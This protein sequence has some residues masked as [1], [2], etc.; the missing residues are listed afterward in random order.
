MVT[1]THRFATNVERGAPSL[2]AFQTLA[3]PGA[4]EALSLAGYD[5]VV[6]DLQHGGASMR[7]L[8]EYVRAVEL[9][10]AA[11]FVRV[12]WP[13]PPDI[14]RAA[15]AGASGIVVPMIESAEQAAMVARSAR[16]PPRGNRS[17]GPLRPGFGGT[18]HA[19]GSLHVVPMIETPGALAA[20]DD[21]VSI[22]GVDG[23]FVGPMD[24]GL[25]LGATA[26]EAI[27]HPDTV[28]GL[29]RVVAAA[30]RHDVVV[31]TIG[32]DPDH[33]DELLGKGVAWVAV[34]SD[35]AFVQSGAAAAVR[36]WTARD[37]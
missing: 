26:A 22:D 31:G 14:M 33:V 28:A 2:A 7:D 1:G 36:S 18:D 16:Y 11:A 25:S 30:A 6:I 17:F 10:G 5:I 32:T 29:D 13:S 37:H 4:A 12:P 23:V 24:L 19:N 35:K 3:D 9:H 27:R 8:P 34:G 21:I 20:V 15:D